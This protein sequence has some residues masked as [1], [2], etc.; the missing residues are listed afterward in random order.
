MAAAHSSVPAPHGLRAAFDFAGSSHSVT[1][2][3]DTTDPW[4]LRG[5]LAWHLTRALHQAGR[6]AGCME[7]ERACPEQLPLGLLAKHV[8]RS[9]ERRFAYRTGLDPAVPAP[10]GTYRTEDEQEFIL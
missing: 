5:N 6:C 3:P 4:T 9:V 1:L 7:C 2:L 10:M 8:A